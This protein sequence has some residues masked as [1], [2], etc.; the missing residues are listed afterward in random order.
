MIFNWLNNLV[1]IY[2]KALKKEVRVTIDVHQLTFVLSCKFVFFNNHI[3]FIQM[4]S[5]ITNRMSP[6]Y[7]SIPSSYEITPGLLM[8]ISANQ[9][10]PAQQSK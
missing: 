2:L 5:P 3:F 8:A 10:L 1:N 9:H 4:A 7:S 6:V